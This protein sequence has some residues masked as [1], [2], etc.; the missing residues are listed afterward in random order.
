MQALRAL[1]EASADVNARSRS[2]RLT[3]LHFTAIFGHQNIAGILVEHGAK[4][5]IRDKFIQTAAEVAS[6][7]GHDVL[8]AALPQASVAEVSTGSTRA[9]RHCDA[10]LGF[11][12]MLQAIVLRE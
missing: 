9:Y 4:T 8:A 7:F 1:L 6:Y 12:S 10:E 5:T 11:A 3:P 2:D